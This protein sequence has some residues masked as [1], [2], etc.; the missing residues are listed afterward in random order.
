MTIFAPEHTPVTRRPADQA[1]LT[2]ALQNPYGHFDEEHREFVITNPATPAP[3]VNYITNGLYHGL[4]SH[5]GGGF[6]FYRSPRDNRITRWR[7]NSLPMDRPGR[8]VYVRDADSGDYWSLTWQPTALKVSNYECRHGMNYTT[9]KGRCRSIASEMTCFV[10]PEDSCEIWWVKLRNTSRRPRRLQVYGYVE[11]CLGHALVDLI[12]QPND[13]HFNDVIYLRDRQILMASKR[14]WVTYNRATVAQPNQEWPYWVFMANTLPVTGFDGSRQQFMGPW[15]SEENPAAVEAGRCLNTEITAGDAVS[16][17]ESSLE[18]APGE[19]REFAI[20]L[21]IVPKTVSG[22]GP[23]GTATKDR[24]GKTRQLDAMSTAPLPPTSASD[25]EKLAVYSKRQDG[26]DTTAA[27]AAQAL[28]AKYRDLKNVRSAYKSLCKDLDDYLSAVQVE[29]PEPAVQVMLNCW[30]PYQVK[31]T[32][33]FSRDASYYHGGMLFGRGFR[34]SCQDTLGPLMTRPEWSRRRIL[35]QAA[36]Q[37]ANGRCYHLYYAHSEGGENTGHSDT[38]LWL[39]FAAC[40]YIKETLD[41]SILDEVVPFVEETP[42]AGKEPPKAKL[43][44]HLLRALEYSIT[45][46]S[47]RNLAYFGPGDWNDTLDY[48]GRGGKG[49]SVWV[50][51]AFCFAAREMVDLL[52]HIER[53]DLADTYQAWYDKVKKAVNDIAWDGEWYWRGTNDEGEII[54]SAACEEGK[55]FI[56]AQS[57]AVISGVADDARA[58]RC[59]DSAW[60]HLRTPKGPKLLHPAYTKV[61]RNIG[62]ATRC[63]PGKKENGAVFNHT[64]AW[65]ILAE[66]MQGRAEQAWTYYRSSLPM[67]PVVSPERFEIEPYVYCEYVTSP[68]HPNFGQASHSW[69]TG[70]AVWMLRTA[71]DYLLGVRPTYDGLLVCPCI[72]AAW[73]GYSIRRKFRGATYSISVSNPDHVDRGVRLIEVDGKRISG[74]VLPDFADGKTHQVR[75]VLGV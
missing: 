47:P 2:R 72:P 70:S 18:L 75:V 28:A 20:V 11:L 15:R 8:Y 25:A 45:R 6:S 55:I 65:A 31:T 13:Q 24:V 59:L 37:F 68:D 42:V 60:K 56:N 23:G 66:A 27:D 69:L 67:N 38:A 48:L 29:V 1:D 46:L 35:E 16:C 50:S 43:L 73:D 17:L 44:D 7:Y 4:V 3:W 49:E 34:D 22:E 10:P 41:T 62:L 21:G 14:Y 53:D 58:T 9:F 30:N 39:P 32:F 19:T 61:N 52:R 54:G 40:Q 64:V 26:L 36:R 57:W 33:Q 74:S 51:M 71:L 63:V 12:N 5:V